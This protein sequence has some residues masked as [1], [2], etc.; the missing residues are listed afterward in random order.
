VTNTPFALV[1]GTLCLGGSSTFIVNL[2]HGLRC[3]GLDLPVV[4]MS[5][6]NYYREELVRAGATFEEF[7]KQGTIYED[8]LVRAASAVARKH[9]RA[10]IASLSP[11]SFEILRYVP[12]GVPRIGMVHADD[13]RVYQALKNYA[14]WTDVMV[15][16][17]ERIVEK[18]RAMPEFSMCRIEYIP[19]GIKF[20]PIPD[21]DRRE[22]T[23]RPL[24]VIYAGRLIEEQKRISRVVEVIRRFLPEAGKPATIEFT[25]VGSGLQEADVRAALE[26]LP[27]V[28]LLGALSSADVQQT[29]L[30]QD[31][32]LL[33]SDYEGLPLALLEAMGAGVV[34]VISDIE[35]GIRH[36]VT[37]DVGFR[38][39]IGNV[40]AAVGV[41]RALAAERSLLRDLGNNA[42]Q[43][44]RTEF[45]ADL[46]AERFLGL[47]PDPAP[48]PLWSKAVRLRPPLGLQPAWKYHPLFRP[49]RRVLTRF[50]K[51]PTSP[52]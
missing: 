32:F 12:I 42:R 31:I 27:H 22:A 9:P 41:L 6:R 46:M 50:Y 38:V 5:A 29:F 44:A 3:R 25:I 37:D 13:V 20:P 15:G 30:E 51:R 23:T 43:R 16:V 28:R 14:P 40:N 52:V 49:V 10:V 24:R 39:P 36:L 21:Y 19:Y 47:L 18:L 7:T 45:S 11:E 48:S 26:H 17:S 2:A 35:S 8:R 1:S 34:P 4:I 33:L